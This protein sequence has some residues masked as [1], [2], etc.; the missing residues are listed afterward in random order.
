MRSFFSAGFFQRRG[1]LMLPMPKTGSVVFLEISDRELP[2]SS[3]WKVRM[4]RVVQFLA[5]SPWSRKRAPRNDRTFLYETKA[6]H[7]YMC[8]YLIRT[9]STRSLPE[10]RMYSARA[11]LASVPALSGV[12]CADVSVLCAGVCCALVCYCCCC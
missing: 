3:T 11:R 5:P 1:M 9:Y 6:L 12:S 4:I 10:G 8:M 7:G 2:E